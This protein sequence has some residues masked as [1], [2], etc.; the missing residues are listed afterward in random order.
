MRL[1]L[2]VALATVAHLIGAAVFPARAGILLQYNFDDHTNPTLNS[3]TL[4]PAY[5]G[6]LQ[7]NAT[8]VIFGPGWAV[9]L[10]GDVSN[11]SV[12]LPGG[13]QSILNI[14]DSDFSLFA[15]FTTTYFNESFS[16]LRPL[17][18]KQS[19]GP[20]PSYS[21]GVR[22]ETGLAQFALADGVTVLRIFSSVPVNDGQVYEV[23]ASRCGA[24]MRLYL[25]GVLDAILPIP[26]T[27]GS[28]H[29][30][31]RLVIGG[32][33]LSVNDDWVGLIDEIRVNNDCESGPTPAH[34]ST[35]GQLKSLSR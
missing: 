32:R 19:I 10:D 27:F 12:V 22:Q 26:S 13:D 18:W 31:E 7:G 21:L 34:R 6:T 11:N 3:G 17:I 2:I 28:T 9:S 24:E 20:G 5:N 1:T 15:R 4:G 30:N 35:W 23:L 25:D 8:F 29:N 33:T 14:G 16:S